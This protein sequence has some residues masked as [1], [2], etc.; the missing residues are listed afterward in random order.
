[1]KTPRGTLIAIGGKEARGPEDSNG[2]ANGA[3]VTFT[4]EGI[5]Q[6]V[7]ECMRG[8]DSHIAVI[9]TASS[10]PQEI[11][12][13]YVEAFGKLGCRQV[14]VLNLDGRNVNAATTLELLTQVDGV[15]LTGGDQARLMEKLDQTAFLELLWKRYNEDHFVIA[16]T[17]A[18]AM[19]LSATMIREGSSEESLLKGI[20]RVQK[21]FNFLPNTIIDTHFLEDRGRSLPAGRG[22]PRPTRD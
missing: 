22:D 21:G 2:K 19:A 9:T 8:A 10:M 14:V 16:G 20:V 5:L 12:D 11:G 15:F 4:D 6:E 13:M 3:Q 1:M 7:L 17:S 18:G